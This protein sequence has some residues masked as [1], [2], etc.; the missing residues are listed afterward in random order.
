MPHSSSSTAFRGN[1]VGQTPWSARVPLDPPAD[2]SRSTSQTPEAGQ[3]AGRGRGRPPHNS[4]QVT[5]F[6]KT[7]RHWAEA[8]GTHAAPRTTQAAPH[9]AQERK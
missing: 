4:I 7:L 9:A 8:R 5:G 1:Q 2:G 6:Q 3:G